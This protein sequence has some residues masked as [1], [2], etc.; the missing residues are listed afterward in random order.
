[1]KTKLL[2]LN[3]YGVVEMSSAE[4]H[5]TEGG[6]FLLGFLIGSSVAVIV[7]KLTRRNNEEEEEQQQYQVQ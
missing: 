6:S 4:M 5:K 1:M 7:W 2:D 3:V